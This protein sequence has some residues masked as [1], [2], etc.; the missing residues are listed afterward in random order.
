MYIDKHIYTH[1]YV[2]TYVC[3]VTCICILTCISTCAPATYFIYNYCGEMTEHMYF[4]G[5]LALNRSFAFIFWWTH[6]AQS[7]SPLVENMYIILVSKAHIARILLI[8]FWLFHW[9]SVR[10]FRWIQSSHP[11]IEQINTI[12]SWTH[13]IEPNH[14]ILYS[15]ANDNAILW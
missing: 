10:I 13:S 6:A 7:L 11:S 15:G 1:V 9:I 4:H 2:H 5:R 3:I 14:R 12:V 8:A